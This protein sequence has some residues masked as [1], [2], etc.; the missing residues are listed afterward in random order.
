MAEWHY[1][2]WEA[3]FDLLV[4]RVSY[5]A[6]VLRLVALPVGYVRLD[7]LLALALACSVSLVLS[8]DPVETA[9]VAIRSVIKL[10]TLYAVREARASYRFQ[11][12]LIAIKYLVL[13]VVL[14]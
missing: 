13:D 3:A 4:V 7:P 12:L 11:V 14:P 10:T 6:E 9:G 8:T 2:V 1:Q 5:A